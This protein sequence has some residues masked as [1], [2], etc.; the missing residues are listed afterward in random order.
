MMSTFNK[1]EFIHLAKNMT[2]DLAL[3]KF[4]KLAEDARQMYTS[5]CELC[6]PRQTPY[7]GKPF[8]YSIRHSESIDMGEG[9]ELASKLFFELD[10]FT[11]K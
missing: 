11:T 1:E 8:F 2:S 7:I 5:L 9:E 10:N 3:A 6:T 4:R